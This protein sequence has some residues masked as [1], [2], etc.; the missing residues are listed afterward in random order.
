MVE[1][2]VSEFIVLSLIV[3][4][5]LFLVFFFTGR[6]VDI[7]IAKE[8]YI[9]YSKAIDLMHAIT[10]SSSIVE[11][12]HQGENLKIILN[13][14]KIMIEQNIYPKRE[15]KGFSYLDYDYSLEIEDLQTKE[16]W[17]LGFPKKEIENFVNRE[18][19]CQE[20]ENVLAS[21]S[22][23][24]V[25][26]NGD[27]KNPGLIRMILAKT[28]I[29]E[30]AYQISALCALPNFVNMG[31][32]G[33]IVYGL[34]NSKDN[35]NIIKISDDQYDLCVKSEN[36]VELCKEMK[37]PIEVKTK[38]CPKDLCKNSDEAGG[39]LKPTIERNQKEVIVYVPEVIQKP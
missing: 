5:T 14:D 31:S 9:E 4:I 20:N 6:Y 19:K 22:I 18:K 24:V 17:N 3:S 38:P 39:C 11:K 23:P 7:N 30:L 10:T 34:Q 12:N 26:K 8:Q 27:N 2:S 21:K 13:K 16:V 25:I 28:P 32:K 29:S 33:V 35:I 37:C 36:S 15:L 1:L